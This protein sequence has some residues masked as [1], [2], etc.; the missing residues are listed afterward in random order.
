MEA[1]ESPESQ[2]H[3]FPDD[4]HLKLFLNF[5]SI[6]TIMTIL[7]MMNLG[8]LLQSIWR[9]DQESNVASGT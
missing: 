6:E 5:K 4:L 7:F 1:G 2:P 8:L 9:S 3:R